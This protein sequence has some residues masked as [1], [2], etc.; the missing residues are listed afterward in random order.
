MTLFWFS[1]VKLALPLVV[2]SCNLF[3]FGT[4]ML[5]IILSPPHVVVMGVCGLYY[6]IW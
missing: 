1:F 4:E 6:R 3:F 5:M 2:R